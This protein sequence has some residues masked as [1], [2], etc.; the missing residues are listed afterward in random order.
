MKRLKDI[1]LSLLLLGIVV[2]GWVWLDLQSA[3]RDTAQNDAV[4]LGDSL[5]FLRGTDRG[6][7]PVSVRL[8][9]GQQMATVVYVYHPD[10][11]PCGTVAPAW[12]QHFSEL[13]AMDSPVRK[14]ALTQARFP[15]ASEFADDFDWHVEIL[16]V[17]GLSIS[18]AE[19]H[20]I[21][22]TPWVFVFD[23]NGVLRLEAHGA[24]VDQVEN[25]LALLSRAPNALHHT[26]TESRNP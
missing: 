2:Q 18:P 23:S 21:S 3:E 16:S 19:R 4:R 9:G 13:A 26:Q 22:R 12:A 6:Q 8:S 24:D 5:P 20:L 14:I 10:C 1:V 11:G 7:A 25:T 17:D 15:A